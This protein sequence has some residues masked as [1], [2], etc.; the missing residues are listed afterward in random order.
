[1]PLVPPRWRLTLAECTRSSGAARSRSEQTARCAAARDERSVTSA[2]P[3]SPPPLASQA[4]SD[5]AAATLA[6]ALVLTA[7]AF[8][9]G[10]AHAADAAAGFAVGGFDSGGAGAEVPYVYTTRDVAVD[11]ASPL[12]AYK[13]ASL[14]FNQEVPV[15]LDAIIYAAALAAAYVVATGADGLD[16]YLV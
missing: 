15:W 2:S 11:L 4:R 7:A 8:A 16:K 6:C 5:G 13:V 12:V 9:A 10:D 14:L 3:P 1:V